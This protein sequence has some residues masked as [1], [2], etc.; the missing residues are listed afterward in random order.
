MRCRRCG[1]EQPPALCCLAC[2]AVQEPAAGLDYFTALR[3]T[4]H[5]AVDPEDVARRYYEL[6]RRLHPDRFQTASAEDQAASV[7]ATA[8]LNAAFQTLRDVETRGRYWLGLLGES[9]GRDNAGV[10]PA[11][12]AYVFEL[13]E[14]LA[15]I[16]SARD[17]HRAQLVAELR[18]AH[19]DLC[20]RRAEQR[21]SVER[22]LR[23]WPH[24]AAPDGNGEAG[25]RAER[26][27][28]QGSSELKRL[29]SELSYLRTLDR[30]VQAAL[31]G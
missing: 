21:A 25:A 6:S 26:V 13:Q 3:L 15:E 8:V 7:H 23:D 27:P 1:Q 12:A 28:N 4:P 18:E 29:L 14:K 9:L 19:A 16:R 30:D 22:M 20:K 11:L 10:P 5:P 17:A 24:G 31:E 2:D